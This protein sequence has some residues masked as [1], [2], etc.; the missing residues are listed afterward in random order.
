M[1]AQARARASRV[2][3]GEILGSGRQMMDD[4]ST[5]LTFHQTKGT[6]PTPLEFLERCVGFIFGVLSQHSRRKITHE[7]GLGGN[8]DHFRGTDS[9]AAVERHETCQF[10]SFG[11]GL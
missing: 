1:K 6:P 11:R 4:L 10:F 3:S 8:S 7:I 9:L 5:R 2:C